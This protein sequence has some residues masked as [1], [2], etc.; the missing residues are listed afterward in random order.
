VSE[1]EFPTATPKSSPV[2]GGLVVRHNKLQPFSLA[3]KISPGCGLAQE[4]LSA[5]VAQDPSLTL[6]TQQNEPWEKKNTTKRKHARTNSQTE[7]SYHLL[8][9]RELRVVVSVTVPFWF[10]AQR[11][12]A[13]GAPELSSHL[14]AFIVDSTVKALHHFANNH[15]VIAAETPRGSVVETASYLCKIKSCACIMM[16]NGL[17]KLLH[18]KRGRVWGDFSINNV[19]IHQC[20]LDHMIKNYFIPLSWAV[21]KEVHLTTL[22]HQIHIAHMLDII[23]HSRWSQNLTYARGSLLASNVHPGARV[24]AHR[25]QQCK[26]ACAMQWPAYGHCAGKLVDHPFWDQGLTDAGR[27]VF[28][29]WSHCR[30]HTT[31][32]LCPATDQPH[33]GRCS[34]SCPWKPRTPGKNVGPSN[35][36]QPGGSSKMV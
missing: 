5:A 7:S 21:W 33:Q 3:S 35:C 10:H 1:N 16:G 32:T 13:R 22:V 29:A 17:T 4:A 23:G 9:L 2:T 14:L 36:G 24:V 12:I 28:P 25:G 15:E 11:N 34:G 31:R 20:H 26:S 30:C 18:I 6:R 27:A 19:G 8:R